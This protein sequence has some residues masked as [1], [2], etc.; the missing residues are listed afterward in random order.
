MGS[1]QT[2][3]PPETDVREPTRRR[4]WLVRGLVVLAS[5]VLVLSI[6]AVWISR[7]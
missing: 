6:L 4:R 3:P 1:E 2:A 7:R 5:I